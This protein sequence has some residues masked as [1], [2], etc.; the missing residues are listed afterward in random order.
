VTQQARNLSWQIEEHRRVRL[1][2]CDRDRKFSRSFAEVFAADGVRV[3]Q[4]PY[5]S[6]RAN[7]HAE[8]WVGTARRE[9]L[10]WL[11]IRGEAHLEH[12]LAEFATHYNA[13]R[14][15]RGLQLR[16]PAGDA[17]TQLPIGRV[18]RRDRL[19]GEGRQKT[20]Q[21]DGA[22]PSGRLLL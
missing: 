20:I 14:P 21:F 22:P 2:I 10:D 8:R 17:V 12:V 3:L 4:T 6:P 19:G 7:A 18:I 15:H 16:P 11:L 9:C 5:R 13:A 1:L